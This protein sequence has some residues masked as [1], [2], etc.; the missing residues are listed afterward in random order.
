MVWIGYA[1]NDENKTV[2][3]VAYSGYEEGYL[4]T[5]QLTW[6][7]NERGRG[8][9]G[10]A[11]RTG[12]PS[13]CRNMLTDPAFTPWRAE[14]IKRGYASSVVIPL[15]EGDKV[16]GAITIYSREPDTF[17]EGE[18]NLLTELAADLAYGIGTLRVRATNAKAEEERA[19]T[20]EFLRLVNQSQGTRDLIQ[21][22]TAFFQQ[23]S[24]CE[25]VG[26]RL[27]EGDDYPYYEA[28][29]F[30]K[31][32]VQVES[33]ICSRDAAGKVIRDSSG[34]PAVE[35]MCGNVIRGRIDPSK[36]FF[37]AQ[38]SFWTNSTTQLL[39]TTADADRQ[40]RTRNRCNGEGYES[41]ALIPLRI[42]DQRLGLLQLNDGP[43]GRFSL[44]TILLWER[45]ADYLAVALSKFRA[46]EAL[47]RQADLLR[48]SFDAIIVWRLGGVIESWNF[49]AEQLYGYSESETLGRVTHELLRTIHPAPWPEIEA[50]LRESGHWEGEL[51][52]FTK[53]G[54]EV[55]VS[56]RQQLIVADGVE[57][58]LETDRDITEHRRAEQALRASQKTFIELVERAPFGIYVVDSQFRIA[59]MNVGS[60]E[61]TFRN[62]R[63]VI[64]RNFSE[65][66]RTLWPEPVAAEIIANFRHTLDTG[67]PYYSRDFVEPR[68]DLETVEGYEWELHR[69]TLSDG[70][71]G[72]ICYYFDST[73]LRT[74][75]VALRDS[76]QQFRNLANAIPQLCWM[77]NAD[78]WIFWYNQRWYQYTGTTPEQM[79]GWG[80]QSVHDPEA[81]PKVMERWKA[82]LVRE[83]PFDMIFPLRGADGVFRP[84]LTRIV[85][86]KDAE[87]KVV[88]WFGTNTDVTDLRNAQEALRASEERWATTLR[89]IGDAVISTCA[90]G[91]IIFM[92]EVA[93]KL[94]GWPL[95]EA[96]GRDLDE[97]FNIV[98]EVTRSKPENP[99][100]KVIHMGQVVGLA[101][102]TALISRNG[103]ELPIEDSGAPIRD[104]Q[105][106]VTGVVLVFHDVSE[107]R[108]VEK[109]LRDSERLATT[110]RLAS[111]LAH[112]I[113]NPLDTVGSLLYL[114]DRAPDVPETVRQHISMAS[115]ELDRVTQM[116][117]HMLSFQREAKKPGPIKIGEVLDNV[118]A[119]YERKIESA[120][121]KV[122][123]QVDF[124]G[125]FIGLP[126]EMRQV[127]AN[128][129]GNA[130][131]AIG[132][133]GKI[134]LHAYASTDWRRGRR[135]LRVT[136]A[137][138]G[139][140]IPADVR[141]KIFE[142][143]FTTKG[144]SGTGLGLWITSGIVEKNDG[145]LRLRTVTRD[146][147]S[148][149]CFS[150][151]FP[152]PT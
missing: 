29:G 45:L 14:A 6:A 34:N 95:C 150:V 53:A 141:G 125:E 74:A 86:I 23:R 54:R 138:N 93:E 116:T 37:T 1:E 76:E 73:K 8:P 113:H 43:K 98:N 50:R 18:V 90:R 148:G 130:I 68:R 44:E 16:F 107:K 144:E 11:I 94:T 134:R 111:T 142:P 108:K 89:S 64:G 81:L 42:G 91:K 112:E 67:E 47:R 52:H 140:G 24:A 104:N 139:P 12:Q 85:P 118:I 110:G 106:Q 124:D 133:N 99:V 78:G 25:A 71:Y 55:V 58:V 101:N 114:I 135:G 59:Q 40:T 105:G 28:R 82:S 31:E 36:P 22:A 3:P 143:F 103:T 127:F 88:R 121:I 119:L 39:A 128:L 48:L 129:I 87:G 66:M 151:F 5:M 115:G 84:F 49:G 132:K 17:A 61:G 152:F 100:A 46:E 72:V 123:K 19:T 102:H 41:V 77:A 15:K 65:A 131:E 27:Q 56:A 97:V 60:Q 145:M 35:C 70:Q 33:S 120:A 62:V 75:E 122:E 146:G 83:E 69:M 20:V 51:H 63:P 38:G 57:R 9:T 79:E 13:M 80:W 137:D 7:D 147:R 117:R 2:R 10:T 109:A 26:I 136:V 32:F 149:T 92:N 126:G 30:P 21:A 4:E 96:Q